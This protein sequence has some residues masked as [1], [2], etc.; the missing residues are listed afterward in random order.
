MGYWETVRFFSV[1]TLTSMLT[2]ADVRGW[3]YSGCSKWPLC[4]VNIFT[5]RMGNL[6]ACREGS[7]GREEEEE[8]E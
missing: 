8:E 6:L 1:F 5:I 3:R 4:A 2:G 7:E